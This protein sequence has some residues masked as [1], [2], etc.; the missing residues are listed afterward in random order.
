MTE[1]DNFIGNFNPNVNPATTPAIQQVGPGA[2][3]PSFYTGNKFNFYPRLGAAWD[4]Q[5]N[6]K[7]V[8]RAG[9]G[10]L[11]NPDILE[12]WISNTPFGANFPALGVNT[13][14]T[15]ANAHSPNRLSFT[16][17]QFNWN[18]TG[19][20]IFPISNTQSFNGVTYTGV[21]CMAPLSLCDTGSNDPN[22]KTIFSAQWNADIQ[23]AITNSLTIDVAYV[24]VHGYRET[25]WSDLNQP[26][27]GTGWN[28][29]WTATQLTNAKL[30][31]P[32]D[33]GLT[34]AQM[35]LG[36][37]PA[38][39][40]SVNT[41]AEAL[42]R[43]YATKFPYLRYIT[44]AGNGGFSNY[45]AMEVTLQARNYHG[46]RFISGYTLAHALDTQTS[47]S[48]SQPIGPDGRNF[49]VIYG[50]GDADIRNRFTFSPTYAIP[51]MK[52]PGQMLE[53]WALSSILTLQTGSP[54]YPLDATTDDF[55][56]TGENSDQSIV[57]S[58]IQTWNYSGPRSAF[59]PGPTSIPC[60]GK[61]AGCTPYVGGT[62]PAECI[63]A[64]QAPYAGNAQLQALAV[65]S[66][67]NSAC[68]EQAGGILT[69]PAYGTIGNAGRGI[70]NGPNYY[71]V[72]LSVSKDWKLKERFGV[73]FRFELF[74]LFNR[75]DFG[76]PTTDPSKGFSGHFGCSCSTPDSSNPVLGSGGPRHIQ[77][78]LKLTY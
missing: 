55:L 53:G 61:L 62:P 14:G 22:Y 74:N 48:H 19:G 75:A 59:K 35:C 54:W 39:F 37:G 47:A 76:A 31:A 1:H 8:I 63:T 40:C 4:V 33:A 72:D 71:N 18:T 66:L 7:T 2:P 50:N 73:Q 32:G 70:F 28:T 57:G 34:S 24:G 25:Q 17:A 3:I 69:P 64:A 9:G 29:P 52:S 27:I 30:G 23:R 44:Q 51:G 20:P 5:G 58:V 21:T 38:P 78:G 77:F 12:H 42:A 16:T 26:A 60:F 36:Q 13:S 6:G 56:G 65:A 45:H 49:H 46:L 15:Q 67:N 10:L 41:A 68:Y 43:P 11:G